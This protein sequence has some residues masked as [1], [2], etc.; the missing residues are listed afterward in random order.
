VDPAGLE[1]ALNRAASLILEVAGGQAAQGVVSAST[2]TFTPTH[3]EFRPGRA[4]AILGT[5]L[6]DEV[7][8]QIL[9][10]LGC[11]VKVPSADKP[12]QVEC[13]TYRLDL[14]REI[15]LIEEIARVNGYDQIPTL[16]PAIPANLSNIES[17][18]PNEKE[19]R[20]ILHQAG[21]MEAVNS[22]FLPLN[23]TQ[24]LKLTPEHP[25]NHF[26]EVANP[27]A[28]DQRVMRP[29][30]LP[31][32]LA[33]V[34]LNLAH[35]R[36]SVSLYEFNK[37]FS[38]DAQG[39]LAERFQVTAVLAGI[40]TGSGWN[41]P[42][43]K[44]DFYDIK[45]LA[46]DL[47][48]YCHVEK[49]KWEFGTGSNPYNAPQSFQVKDE[50]GELLLWG[51]SLNRKVLKEY[52]ISA[53]C[54][55]LE[56]EPAVLA[57][58]SKKQRSFTALPKFPAAWRDIALVVPDGVTSEQVVTAV[59]EQGLPLL[60]QVRLF[61]LYKG[62]NLPAGMRSLAYRLRFLNEE[63]TMTDKEVTDKVAQIVEHLKARYSIVQ[64]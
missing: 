25:L 26:Q 20:F 31:S 32:L 4:N 10:S 38:L 29:T 48:G 53:P 49:A 12:L 46:E 21:Y 45:G 19:I 6:S 57:R 64:R 17:G 33:N 39:I 7:Q 40:N 37:I 8:I 41:Q 60:K 35:Q 28:D 23:F 50:E 58:A 27:I 30:L 51:G 59:E 52:D 62:P 11:T 5:N 55:A 14:T 13:P 22:T 47:L 18:W 44:T 56:I 24:K 43:R 3:L 34:Q 2:Q 1:Q 54:F 63:R 15:D 36:E 42:E 61:D 9:K 16:A